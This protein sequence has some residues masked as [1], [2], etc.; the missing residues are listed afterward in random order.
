MIDDAHV[1]KLCWSQLSHVGGVTHAA[2]YY[3][4]VCGNTSIFI[5]I[6]ILNNF[7]FHTRFIQRFMWFIEGV[8][9]F[10]LFLLFFPPL[11]LSNKK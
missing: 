10:I 11:F 6:F 8:Y 1:S 4:S 9:I 7:L 5:F 3:V 2:A